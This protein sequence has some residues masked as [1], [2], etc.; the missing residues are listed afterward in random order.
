MSYNHYGGGGAPTKE[1]KCFH[2]RNCYLLLGVLANSEYLDEI[3]LWWH[4][5]WVCTVF[6][7]FFKKNCSLHK[8]YSVRLSVCKRTFV[9]MYV[10][11]YNMNIPDFSNF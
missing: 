2:S 4:F 11:M 1:I 7:V 3:P 10:C 6:L 8:G 5:I 9:Y